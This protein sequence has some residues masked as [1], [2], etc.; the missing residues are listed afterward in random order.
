MVIGASLRCLSNH[1]TLRQQVRQS[2]PRVEVDME[3][4]GVCNTWMCRAGVPLVPTIFV[5]PLSVPTISG[6]VPTKCAHYFG[7]CAHYFCV[8]TKCAHYFGVCAH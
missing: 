6:V 4:S 3:R 2:Q 5:C 7:W 1:R 8:P